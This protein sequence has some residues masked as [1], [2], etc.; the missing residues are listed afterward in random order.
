MGGVALQKDSEKKKVQVEIYGNSYV[1]KGDT[2]TG[3]ILK[4]AEFVNE[5][6][7]YI[8]QRNPHLSSKQVAILTALNLADELLTLQN[9]Y[10]KLVQILEEGK[11][12]KKF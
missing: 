1:I 8:G 6:M 11:K 3:S 2:N 10:D 5:K 12:I 9:D 4:V 7:N